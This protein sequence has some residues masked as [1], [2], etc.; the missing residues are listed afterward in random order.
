MEQNTNEEDSK[1]CVIDTLQKIEELRADILQSSHIFTED[2]AVKF[3]NT[4][5]NVKTELSKLLTPAGLSDFETR[6]TIKSA[7]VRFTT[8]GMLI[9]AKL[10]IDCKKDLILRKDNLSE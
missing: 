8:V 1:V 9:T 3:D 4:L 2:E 5:E 10:L 6:L 7:M